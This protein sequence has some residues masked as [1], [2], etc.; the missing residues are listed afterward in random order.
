MSEHAIGATSMLDANYNTILGVSPAD[1]F[2]TAHQEPKT[3]G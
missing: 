1:A 3:S 2:P